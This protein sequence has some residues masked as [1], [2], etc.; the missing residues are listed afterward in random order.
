MIEDPEY[1]RWKRN[2]PRFPG[3]AKCVELLHRRN[4]QG[5][6]VDIICLELVE[7][8]AA[9]AAELIAAVREEQD[10]RVRWILLSVLCDAKLPAALP[11]FVEELQSDDERSRTWAERGL[12]E[13]DTPES[14]RALWELG[15]SERH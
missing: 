13:L 9:H 2:Y 8:A 14:R 12:R 11:V 15:R 10:Q 4:V 7:H 6:T 5:A 3:V 1:S